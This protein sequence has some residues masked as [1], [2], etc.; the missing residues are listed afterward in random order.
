MALHQLIAIGAQNS[1]I[2]N[3]FAKESICIDYDNNNQFIIPHRSDLFM[4]EYIS[5]KQNDNVRRLK[6][7][8]LIIGGCIIFS[9]DISFLSQIIPDTIIENNDNTMIYKLSMDKFIIEPIRMIALT[10]HEVK[11]GVDLE[12][13]GNIE[14]IKLYGTNTLLDIEDRNQMSSTNYEHK[15]FQL[16]HLNH[17]YNEN[18]YIQPMNNNTVNIEFYHCTN[19]FFIEIE[20]I[21]SLQNLELR[22]NSLTRL[23]YNPI[24][25]QLYCKKINDNMLYL[26][27]NSVLDNLF[28]PSLNGTLNM[29][30]IDNMSLNCTSSQ[31][32][33]NI[34]IYSITHN[35]LMYFEGAGCL[36][37]VNG[38]FQYELPRINNL[39]LN[40]NNEIINK[41]Y[42]LNDNCPISLTP[43]SQNDLYMECNEC[44][45]C[46][47]LEG[48]KTWLTN[49]N[50]CPICR[51]F[52]SNVNTYR[53]APD[54]SL[55]APNT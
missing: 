36:K 16:Q 50:T 18:Q 8:K 42:I 30:R 34:N 37:W 20:N 41:P 5:I 31:E 29:S 44:H 39:V 54:T 10:Y 6:S 55:N 28:D 45:K 43:I 3:R 13:E 24:Q 32:I 52:F 47:H 17:S 4:P 14:E 53:N 35:M 26:P 23:N 11:I 38:G 9:I 19:G 46:F 51:T 2:N 40:M 22:L 12:D 1:N 7:Y 15:I 27:L 33:R 25:L 48:I 21:S 49:N